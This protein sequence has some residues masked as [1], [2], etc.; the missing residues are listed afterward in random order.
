MFIVCNQ[1]PS[2]AL[3]ALI[4]RGNNPSSDMTARLVADLSTP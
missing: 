4:P 1:K 3:I 2:A